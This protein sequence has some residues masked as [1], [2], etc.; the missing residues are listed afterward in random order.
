MIKDRY[1]GWPKLMNSLLVSQL[2]QQAL[3]EDIGFQDVT[4]NAIIPAGHQSEG[5]IIAKREGVIAGLKT[6]QQVFYQLD[7][8]LQF[9][10]LVEEG[11][12]VRPGTVIAE[13][14]GSTRS[15]LTG[16]RV[17]LNL[18][19]RMSGI[20]TV[21]RKAVEA[22]KPYAAKITDTRKTTPG[23]RMLEKYAVV[24]GGGINHR[25]RLDDAV[26]IKD[27]H[28]A[29]AGGITAAVAVVREKIGHLIKIEVEAETL[30]QVEEAAAC[31]VDVIMLDNMPLEMMRQA[32]AM[33]PPGIVTEASG[34]ITL[35]NVN[36]VASTG[37][38]VIS[39][40]WLTHSVQALDISLNIQGTV[41]NQPA[42]F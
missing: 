1:G 14:Q 29:V 40:G 16:E 27:N 37:V 4:S 35:D 24:T 7:H 5:K 36:L 42:Q 9:S 6:A 11:S 2:I 10:A 19:Q 33:V 25:F 32:V 30:Q 8:T 18:L 13:I 17:A 34:G 15:I 28:I 12:L 23:L 26:L 20:A 31:G 22:V 39:L 21:T 3:L 41:K 38:Q